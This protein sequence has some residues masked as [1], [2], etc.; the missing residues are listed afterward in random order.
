MHHILSW[1]GRAGTRK[2]HRVAK[3]REKAVGSFNYLDIPRRSQAPQILIANKCS[4]WVAFIFPVRWNNRENMWKPLDF[5]SVFFFHLY[6]P[7]YAVIDCWKLHSHPFPH[8]KNDQINRAAIPTVP[9]NIVSNKGEMER[10]VL[11]TEHLQAGSPG[12]WGERPASSPKVHSPTPLVISSAVLLMQICST[13]WGTHRVRT[14][15]INQSIYLGLAVFSQ[16]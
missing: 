11:A 9:D 6:L 15:K 7:N 8:P 5:K 10:I 2:D 4:C 16:R 3:S 14:E 13:P 12:P 1:T